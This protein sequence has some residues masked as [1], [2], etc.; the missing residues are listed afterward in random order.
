MKKIIILLFL[1]C[2]SVNSQMYT[3]TVDTTR[4][5]FVTIY[6]VNHADITSLIDVYQYY[7]AA[8]LCD[9]ALKVGDADMTAYTLTTPGAWTYLGKYRAWDPGNLYFRKKNAE[10]TAVTYSLIIWGIQ[11]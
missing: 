11:K 3:S 8:I 6:N 2:A 4:A 10:T 1:F 9:S 5:N 7:E